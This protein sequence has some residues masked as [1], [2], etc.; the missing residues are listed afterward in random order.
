MPLTI[1]SPGFLP[2]RRAD[3]NTEESFMN[4][5][6]TPLTL[7][8]RDILRAARSKG[9]LLGRLFVRAPLTELR[10]EYVRFFLVRLPYSVEARKFHFRK[11]DTDGA[12]FVAVNA[13]YG[14]CAMK[15]TEFTLAP[16]DG[17]HFQGGM[18]EMNEAEAGERAKNFAR[19]VVMRLCRNLPHFGDV[20]CESFFRPY[21]IAYYRDPQGTR[22]RY[23]PF[24][25][26]GLTFKR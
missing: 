16:V 23:L 3:G 21:W 26:D 10:L 7:D 1:R 14:K 18:F 25:A 22:P 2:A 19:R 13:L 5:M 17:I 9:G 15:D 4:M 11:H 24:E 20:R 8:R 6:A 12:M